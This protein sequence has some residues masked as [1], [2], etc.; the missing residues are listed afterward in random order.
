MSGSKASIL[1]PYPGAAAILCDKLHPCGF[2]GGADSGKSIRTASISACLDIANLIPNNLSG[3]TFALCG[4]AGENKYVGSNNEEAMALMALIIVITEMT[5]R[6]VD[7]RQ[8][9]W[10]VARNSN[11][12]AA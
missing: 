3:L 4:L 1:Q 6:V 11:G 7:L 5:R 2:E 9:A 10:E 8:L 12:R